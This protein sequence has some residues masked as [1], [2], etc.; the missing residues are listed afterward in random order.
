MQKDFKKKMPPV[1]FYISAD[2]FKYFLDELKIDTQQ[3]AD[4]FGVSPMCI[5]HW[6]VLGT[7]SVT[8]ASSFCQLL[9]TLQLDLNPV[10]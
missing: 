10:T 2:L 8:F 1:R 4:L 3:A 6:R 7:C 9:D 5:Y